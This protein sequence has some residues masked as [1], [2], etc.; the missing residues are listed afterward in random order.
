MKFPSVWGGWGNGDACLIGLSHSDY[1]SK[2]G[3]LSEVKSC[4]IGLLSIKAMGK[5]KAC[6]YYELRQWGRKGR[7]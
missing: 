5:G 3:D 7:Q 2:K 6:N 4:L 1:Q